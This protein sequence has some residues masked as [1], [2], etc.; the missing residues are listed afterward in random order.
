MFCIT[1][2]LKKNHIISL[3]ILLHTGPRSQLKTVGV[4]APEQK[5]KKIG[6]K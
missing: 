6:I 4:C 5:S 2:R 1:P 3:F